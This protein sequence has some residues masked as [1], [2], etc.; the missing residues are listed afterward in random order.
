MEGVGRAVGRDGCEP[1]L[2]Y[3]THFSLTSP[4]QAFP[5]KSWFPLMSPWCTFSSISHTGCFI[6][7]V[8]G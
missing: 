8:S 3:A 4:E 6:N 5:F 1:L 2:V 7:T